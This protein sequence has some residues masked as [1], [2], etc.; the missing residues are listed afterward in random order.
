MAVKI[1]LDIQRPVEEVFAFMANPA[2]L[3]FYDNS[4]LEV[5]QISG[6]SIDEG[7][8][9][10][11]TGSQFG[12]RMTVILEITAYDP[13]NH[14]ALMVHSGPFPVKTHYTL[15]SLGNATQVN[16][17]REPIPNGIWQWLTPLM[18]IPARSKF[19]A[20]LKSLKNYLEQGS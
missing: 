18:S 16:G 7:A 6:E 11:L 3:P 20:E 12:I 4:F 14:Y 19:K 2:Y 13:D 1:C 8:K 9:F 5:K 17:K 10:Q 15:V